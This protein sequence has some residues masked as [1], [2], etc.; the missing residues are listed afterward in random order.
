MSLSRTVHWTLDFCLRVY[1]AFIIYY[2]V[3]GSVV[4]TRD[5]T[6]ITE[7]MS[8]PVCTRKCEVVTCIMTEVVYSGDVDFFYALVYN[9]E[10]AGAIAK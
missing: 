9:I 4:T 8:A 6:M 10:D 3:N 7:R 5:C 1:I 2:L